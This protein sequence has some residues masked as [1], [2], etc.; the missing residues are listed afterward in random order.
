MQSNLSERRQSSRHLP[1]PEAEDTKRK[2]SHRLF[3]LRRTTNKKPS[4]PNKGLWLHRLDGLTWIG[5]WYQFFCT[6]CIMCISHCL[7]SRVYFGV[8]RHTTSLFFCNNMENG[9][10]NLYHQT[11]TVTGL[12]LQ[13]ERDP[14]ALNTRYGTLLEAHRVIST[15]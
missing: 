13:K 10:Y 11:I 6:S 3:S 14:Q 15:R 2:G 12:I 1:L 4:T 5:Y 8:T 9:Y 7:S